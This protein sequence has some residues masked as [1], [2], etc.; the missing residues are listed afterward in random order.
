[1]L[2]PG[3]GPGGDIL[4]EGMSHFSTMLL[5]EAIRGERERIEFAKR[6][7][8]RYGERRQVDSERP[9]Y[10]L[11]GS[12]D[13]DETVTYDKGGWVFWMLLQ[14]MGRERALE[15]L[16]EFL[17]RY[18]HQPDHPVLQDFVATMRE[19]ATDA[20]AFDAFTKQWFEQV[21]MPEYKLSDARSQAQDG[22]WQVT[23]TLT[24][25]G[26]GSM[27]IEVCA[28][29]GTRFPESDEPDPIEGAVQAAEK[30][31]KPE[32]TYREVRTTLVL[33]AGESQEITLTAE[34]EPERVLV[35][36]DCLVLQLR[37]EQATVDL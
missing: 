26:T 24:N 27:P 11:D 35:D 19:F 13:G 33:G 5:I 28:A 37:R 36:P 17:S 20:P 18:H 15:G 31:A 30:P 1:L 10:K 25:K 9:L 32:E 14:H 12:R 16:R 21:V 22:Q 34:F 6:I 3:K 7:E 29:R 23:V 8:T 2:V 4:S